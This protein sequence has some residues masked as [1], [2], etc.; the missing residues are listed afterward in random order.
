[1][2]FIAQNEI[3][4]VQETLAHAHVEQ[5]VE[6]SPDS[7]SSLEIV[8]K[9]LAAHKE[10]VTELRGQLAEKEIEFQVMCLCVISSC[11]GH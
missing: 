2:F 7:L 6:P 11:V 1:M 9:E 8:Q 4:S 3:R 10:M 5:G